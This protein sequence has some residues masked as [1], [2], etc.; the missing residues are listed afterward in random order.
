M[1]QALKVMLAG[2]PGGVNTGEHGEKNILEYSHGGVLVRVAH[3]DLKLYL[4]FLKY[5]HL[6]QRN[7]HKFIL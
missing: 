6:N 5:Q 3:W 7:D 1:K 4:A 2:K